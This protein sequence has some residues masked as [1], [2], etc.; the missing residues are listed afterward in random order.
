MGSVPL[1]SDAAEF[2]RLRVATYQRRPFGDAP[3]VKALET[4]LA[5]KLV[6]KPMGRPPKTRT[7][8]AG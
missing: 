3:F 2:A 8:A 6:P 5:R 1:F 4:H 7:A